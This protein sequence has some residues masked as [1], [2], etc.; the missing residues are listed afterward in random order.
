TNINHKGLRITP[1]PK[2]R[3]GFTY[4]TCHTLT[5]QS[6]KRLGYLTASPHLLATTNE[7]PTHIT[8]NHTQSMTSRS[9]DG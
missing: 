9:M 5:P 7:D 8:T 4:A 2:M 3:H 6:N 1:H